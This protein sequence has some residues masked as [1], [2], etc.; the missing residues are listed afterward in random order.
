MKPAISEISFAV[1]I[2]DF[3]ASVAPLTK[4]M[5]ANAVLIG[6]I[7]IYLYIL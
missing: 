1:P 4:A 6:S 7:L 5:P 3:I 2:A